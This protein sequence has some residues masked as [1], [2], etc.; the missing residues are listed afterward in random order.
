MI[1]PRKMNTGGILGSTLAGAATGAAA[2]GIGAIP[3]AL[4]GLGTGV[5]NTLNENKQKEKQRSIQENMLR[6]QRLLKRKSDFLNQLEDTPDNIPLLPFGG[7]IPYNNETVEL[8]KGESFMTPD[9]VINSIST[10][11]PTH[12]Q[13]GVTIDLPNG[14]EV[15]GKLDSAKGKQF[16]EIGRK[17]EK[18]QSKYLKELANNPTSIASNTSKRMLDNIQKDF[19]EL[20]AEQ[21]NINKFKDGGKVK[22]PNGGKITTKRGVSTPY[23]RNIT[24]TTF[25][26]QLQRKNILQPGFDT[27]SVPQINEQIRKGFNVP[28]GFALPYKAIL[29]PDST[30]TYQKDFGRNVGEFYDP[31]GTGEVIDTFNEP[32]TT[33]QTGGTIGDPNL[34]YLGRPLTGRNLGAGFNVQQPSYTFDDS[35]INEQINQPISTDT[36]RGFNLSNTLST[37]GSLAPVALNIYRGLGETEELDPSNYYNPYESNVRSL[38]KNRRYNVEPELEA[39]RLAQATYYRNLRESAPSQSQFLGGLQAGAISKSRADAQTIARQQNINNQYLAEQAQLDAQLGA[40]RAQTRLGIDQFN[41]QSDAARRNILG[42]G[43]TQLGQFAQNKQLMNNQILR[44][45]QRLGLLED[46]VGNYEFV[47]GKWMFKATG[48]EQSPEDVMNFIKGR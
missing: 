22:Y 34:N 31:S 5:L 15:L 40:Q 13:G 44:D 1:R 9:G 35:S 23:Y 46:L 18:E 16:K 38:M 33:F 4:I 29:N 19:D 2:G 12:E 7:L 42:S 6:E 3:G 20:F 45:A 48:K 10:N 43:L 39:N 28:E 8:E 11:A 27:L 21:E 26:Q 47:D 30:I 25:G 41:L 17:L 37:I 32:R 24:P 14:T 36:N